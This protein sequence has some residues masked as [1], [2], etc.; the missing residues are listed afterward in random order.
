MRA[1]E[2]ILGAMR[3]ADLG[4]VRSE[5]QFGILRAYLGRRE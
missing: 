2:V 3:G 1:P 5:V 4:G